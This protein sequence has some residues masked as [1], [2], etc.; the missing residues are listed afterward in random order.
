MELIQMRSFVM[1]A[2]RLH[3]GETARLLHI[4]QPALT[5]RIRQMEQEIG[6]SLFERTR[7]GVRL[8]DLGRDLLGVTRELLRET[9][10]VLER[11]QRLARGE[12]GSLNIGF[13]LH[14]FELVP[15]IVAKLKANTPGVHICLRDM[16][17]QEQVTALR[18]G[19]IDVGFVRLP[20]SEEFNQKRV[21]KDSLTLISS[22]AL[23]SGSKKLTLKQC[24][25][26]PFVMLSQQRS[27]TF[28]KH[29]VDLCE[30][31]GFI[32]KIVQEA[33]DVPT[34]IA[35]ARAGIGYAF[36]PASACRTQYE[37]IRIHPIS[38]P[39]A[40]W[41]VGAAWRK[42]NNGMILK[43]FLDEIQYVEFR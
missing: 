10:R 33:D 29:A 30:R 15:R 13:G 3:F 22:S 21:I 12:L 17:T 37:G 9:D 19:A 41:W 25:D 34:I 6:G 35:L 27:P 43:R 40:E 7:R 42:A 8:S 4:S 23:Y 18:S 2:E 24:K 36:I 1:L 26:G 31:H 5:K 14:T 38:D 11:A 28:Y 32:P 20:V 16:S 39:T